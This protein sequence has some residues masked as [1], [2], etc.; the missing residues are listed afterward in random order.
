MEEVEN[1]KS[2]KMIAQG[3]REVC[4]NGRDSLKERKEL[5]RKHGLIDLFWRD[6]PVED[7][8]DAI[9]SRS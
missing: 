8:Q 5:E 9:G 7:A 6:M 2:D 1:G 3:L 4:A